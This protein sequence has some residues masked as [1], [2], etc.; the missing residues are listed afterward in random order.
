MEPIKPIMEVFIG[1]YSD[2]TNYCS[3]LGKTEG[4]CELC[5]KDASLGHYNLDH[6]KNNGSTPLSN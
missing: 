1:S 6:L 4:I 3:H 2:W 5:K